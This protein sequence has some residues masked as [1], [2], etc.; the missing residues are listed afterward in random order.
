[1]EMK[2]KRKKIVIGTI[3]IGFTIIFSI[4]I[5]NSTRVNNNKKNL[6][7][8]NNKSNIEM[9]LNLKDIPHENLININKI[10]DNKKSYKIIV[11][12]ALIDGELLFLGISLSQNF[13]SE[14]FKVASKKDYLAHVEKFKENL[15]NFETSSEFEKNMNS[16]LI[17]IFS[18][19]KLE[20]I[21]VDS[22]FNEYISMF[23]TL[24]NWGLSTDDFLTQEF[25][26]SNSATTSL[27]NNIAV[28]NI[29][30]K[31]NNSL[32]PLLV[33]DSPAII[34]KTLLK[35][36]KF[37]TTN[38]PENFN[39][40]EYTLVY[41]L[42]PQLVNQSTLNL[43]IT[44]DNLSIS[45]YYPVTVNP[46]FKTNF[47]LAT[48]NNYTKNK[49][50]KSFNIDNSNPQKQN[51]EIKLKDFVKTNSFN[52]LTLEYQNF[53]DSFYL[54]IIFQDSKNKPLKY[55]FNYAIPIQDTNYII[56]IFPKTTEELNAVLIDKNNKKID[57]ILIK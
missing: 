33:V 12:D 2:K 26:I 8:I 28:P 14:D 17:N 11:E 38:I 15:K 34:N 47:T 57:S 18:N 31:I 50:N 56:C 44:V 54:P 24:Y 39:V 43:E 49:L 22:K 25:K 23:E 48:N 53:K 51:M 55:L 4:F 5:V 16:T 42:D 21:N 36:L 52:Y 37:N 10:Y 3:F 29:S 30:L 13:N 45:P 32:I 41:K 19:K 6:I 20:N 7:N 27:M 9:S 40:T 1:M 35:K 46:N